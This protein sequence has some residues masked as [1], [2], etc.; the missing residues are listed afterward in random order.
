MIQILIAL[1]IM[2]DRGN[3]CGF[4]TELNDLPEPD[5]IIAGVFVNNSFEMYV[6]DT[7]GFVLFGYNE[8]EE[9][10]LVCART[11]PDDSTPEPNDVY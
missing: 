4:G 1:L 9:R 3:L 7:G 11:F 5:H 2:L 6:L 10:G 8:D